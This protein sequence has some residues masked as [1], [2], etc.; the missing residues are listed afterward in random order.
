MLWYYCDTF[1][2]SI[3][4]NHLLNHH[5]FHISV[6]RCIIAILE[7]NML[8]YHNLLTLVVNVM[9]AATAPHDTVAGHDTDNQQE[10]EAAAQAAKYETAAITLGAAI[11]ILSVA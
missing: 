5:L 1:K 3:L 7:N 8:L 2:M 4:I 11:V 10:Q 9:V 6:W